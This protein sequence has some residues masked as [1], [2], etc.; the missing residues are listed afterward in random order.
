MLILSQLNLVQL[1]MIN[2]LNEVTI[3]NYMMYLVELGFLYQLQ[4]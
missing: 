4:S 2:I 3:W 1:N